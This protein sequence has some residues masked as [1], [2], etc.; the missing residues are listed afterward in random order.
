MAIAL[1]WMILVQFLPKIMVWV[2]FALAIIML[3]ITAIVF[4]IDS[5]TRMSHIKGWAIAIAV[6]CLILAL[7]LIFYVIVHRRRIKIC[8]AFLK[9]AASMLK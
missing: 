5:N 8:G 1:I 7:M 3:I 6:I 9:H 2:A 4:L